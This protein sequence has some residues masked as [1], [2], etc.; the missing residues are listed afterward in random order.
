MAVLIAGNGC[1]CLFD[2][3]MILLNDIWKKNVGQNDFSHKEKHNI[4]VTKYD[5]DL[6]DTKQNGVE[7]NDIQQNVSATST[8]GW[9]LPK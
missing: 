5:Q 4:D 9:S 1:Q 2:A 8:Q 6:I 7:Q 3:K